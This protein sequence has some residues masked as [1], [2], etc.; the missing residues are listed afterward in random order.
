MIGALTK[1]IFGTH[2]D[3][4]LKSLRPLVQRINEL[5]PQY[6]KLSDQEL[7][8]WTAK[9]K[10]RVDKGESLDSIM[11]EAFAVVREAAVRTL[12]MR[13]FDVQLI[14]GAVLHQGK[15]AEMKTGEGKTLVATLPAYLNALTGKGVHIVTVNDYLAKRDAE[16]MGRVYNFLGVS[17]GVVYAGQDSAE[18]R[19]AYQADITYG[20][21]N[22]IGFDY[23]RDNMKFSA[24]ELFQRGHAYAIVD[25]VDSILIDEARTP[26]IISGPAEDSTDKYFTVNKII[27]KLKEGEHYEVDLKTKHPTLTEAGIAKAEELLGIEN[28]YDPNN[29]E[30]LHH[31]QQ[32][33]KAHTTLVRDVDY[34]VK[35]G[36]VIIVD[37]F[38]GRLM[39]GRRWSDGL[40]QAV[41]AKEGLKIARENQTLASITFQNLFR[42]YDKLAGMTGTADTEA[43]EFAEIYNLEVVV[44]PTN[45][46]MIRD[47]QSDRVFRTRK[48]KYQAVCEDIVEINKTGQPILVGTVSI[49]QSESLSKY[50]SAHGIKHN[51]LNA[52]HHEREA[53]IVAQA[54][55]YGA[56][57]ISTNMAGRGTD[58]LLGGNP[59][60][61]AMAETGTKDRDDPEF[62]KALEKYKA[63]C[64]EEKKKVIEA[65]GLFI[66]GTERHESRRI[67]NQLRGRAGRQGDPGASRFYVS[68]EDDLMQRFGGERIKKLMTTLGW[69]EGVAIDGRLISKTVENAQKKV[70]AF[71]FE[72]RKHVTEYDDVMNKQRQVVY[73]LRRKI[74]FKDGIRE[75]IM[76]MID[77]LLES[78]V[79]AVCDEK[80]RPVDWD[81]D[82]LKERFKFLFNKECELSL[83]GK[84]DVQDIFD[85]LREQ[86]HKFYLEHAAEQDRK[87]IE[88]KDTYLKDSEF[89][90]SLSPASDK[91]FD[92]RFESIEQDTMLESLDHFWNIHLQEMD[93]LREGIG[94]RGYGQKNPKHEYQREGFLLFQ[95]MF[96]NLQESVVRKLFYF[97][98]SEFEQ[99]LQHFQAE[100]ARRQQR[101]RDMELVH[102][103]SD[104]SGSSGSVG[105]PVKKNPDQER[106][107]LEAQRKKR[108][109][110]RA[111]K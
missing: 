107:R 52:K 91:A 93:Y 110:K 36:Q 70:E 80:T 74:L 6:K 7:R 55:R 102:E 76:T 15:I 99:V 28:L 46:P 22:E 73:N 60:F 84:I 20:Q 92:F 98:S 89:E 95:Q 71:H 24:E 44:I 48:E 11:P 38:T 49:E 57:T 37:E 68:L 1:K 50:L 29:I 111:R 53:E 33:L 66:M 103:G 16:W 106:A 9:F 19:R 27:P 58:I 35:D 83:N 31:V 86:A 65:G 77:D 43:A 87:L 32:A 51:V 47:D 75:E 85:Q 105:I 13:H 81:L 8:D 23:L 34:V 62:Q 64:A 25:E 69:E 3:R 88:L 61:L 108:R 4:V 21:N 40:H 67:D 17:V 2:N 41:E 104:A 5:E 45:K 18:K 90:L 12:G 101:T 59:E 39:P 26:L 54:G 78:A 94:L 109:K 72:S 97:N 56:V 63:I 14:G 100:I 96:S 10:E 79:L 42:M 30:W 82:A